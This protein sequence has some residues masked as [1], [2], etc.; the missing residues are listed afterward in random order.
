MMINILDNFE[1][2]IQDWHLK[3]YFILFDDFYSE[4]YLFDRVF[5]SVNICEFYGVWVVLN[6][7]E[8]TSKISQNFKIISLNLALR[9]SKAITQKVKTLKVGYTS[10]LTNTMNS[11]LQSIEHMP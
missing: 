10:F 9:N 6:N 4:D 7:G 8:K 3:K 1:K 2:L 11:K 5:K